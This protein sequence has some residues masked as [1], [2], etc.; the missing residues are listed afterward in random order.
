LDKGPLPLLW[1]SSSAAPLRVKSK[2]YTWPPKLLCWGGGE[3]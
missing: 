2:S 3:N 1:S